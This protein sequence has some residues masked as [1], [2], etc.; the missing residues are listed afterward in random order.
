VKCAVLSKFPITD[1]QEIFVKKGSRTILKVTL[2]VEKHPFIMFV[3][4]WKSKSGPESRRILYAGALKTAI[5]ALDPQT[6]FV[7]LGDFNSNYNEFHTFRKDKRLNDTYGRTGINHILGTIQN[8]RLVDEAMLAESD[9]KAYLYNL[10]LETEESDRWSH[11]FFWKKGSIDNILVPQSLY[12][13][14]GISY[15]DNSFARFTPSYLFKKNT[16]YRWQ[17]AD[18]GKGRHLGR[19]F[20]DHLPI[21][22]IFTTRPF[23]ADTVASTV[24]D[25]P[26]VTS[27]ANLYKVKTGAVNYRLDNCAV[28]YKHKGSA[29]IKQAGGRAIFVYKTAA[30]LKWG[31]IYQLTVKRLENYKGLRE[32]TKIADVHEIADIDQWHRY[33]HRDFTVDLAVSEFQNE[34]IGRIEGIYQYGSLHYGDNK[35]ICLYFGNKEKLRPQENSKIVLRHVRISFYNCPQIVIEKTD[36]IR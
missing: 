29:I 5:D 35:K 6:D 27:I 16:T 36:Q 9:A 1:T 2:S 32:I 10:W 21:S 19:G 3:C 33:L 25:K 12:D 8:N 34:V 14:K 18:K 13:N 23:E 30:Q 20:S 15:Q 24:S 22:A 17:L 7:V 31:K 4:H 11:K 28:I 26:E